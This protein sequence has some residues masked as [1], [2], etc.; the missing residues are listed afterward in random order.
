MT[1][2]N[3]RLDPTSRRRSLRRRWNTWFAA[4]ALVSVAAGLVSVGLVSRLVDRLHET[5][6]ETALEA[7]VL[8]DLGPALSEQH[9]VAH[10]VTDDPVEFAEP[11]LAADRR[12]LAVLERALG[13]LD[14][15][16]EQQLLSDVR[17]EWGSMYEFLRSIAS[18]GDRAVA[19][20]EAEI[21]DDPIH[22]ELTAGYGRQA[23]AIG[24]LQAGVQA[25][26]QDGLLS[27]RDLERQVLFVV[28]AASALVLL[29]I[30]AMSRQLRRGVIVPVHE[31]ADAA[32]ALGAGEHDRRP[33]VRQDDEIGDLA[34]TFTR[35]ADALA[36]SHVRLVERATQDSL[37]GLANRPS[38][39]D[40][41]AR[42][43]EQPEQYGVLFIDL[44]DFKC[45]NDTM[46]HA[47]GDH[48]LQLVADRLVTA[49]RAADL[50]ARLGGDEFAVILSGPASAETAMTIA[51]RVLDGFNLPFVLDGRE[52]S[53][54][55]SIGVALRSTGD[56][57]PGLLV[58]EADAVMYLAKSRGKNRVELY[59][60][61]AHAAL[62]LDPGQ[63]VGSAETSH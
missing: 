36:D 29:F 1:D 50:V 61:V 5:S 47:A 15:P 60:E 55:A 32:R 14:E 26:A 37:T 27:A 28:G 2:E 63:L 18:D 52:A 31:L 8:S 22:A 7:G 4:L 40:T 23:A 41:L 56:D 16:R 34:D 44:D 49:V 57:N 12:T 3:A 54:G 21:D 43:C 45:V 62:L 42:L 58:R 30:L 39:D 25:E 24:V 13:Q 6:R 51:D 33:C 38:F 53:V 19:F 17:S 46:G 59:D 48:L 10:R 9:G 20:E 35:M 11:F